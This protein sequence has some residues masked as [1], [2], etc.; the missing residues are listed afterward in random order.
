MRTTEIFVEQVIVGLLVL[1]TGALPFMNWER[2]KLPMNDL[3]AG[4]GIL[5]I[6]YLLGIVFD[7]FAD[8]LL[9]RAETYHRLRFAKGIKEKHP[10]S[11]E[12]KRDPYPED[13]MRAS[14]LRGGGKAAEYMEYLRARIRLSRAL[15]V[16]APALSISGLL[17]LG[18]KTLTLK[19]L[20]ISLGIL[21]LIY[22]LIF[23]LVLVLSRSEGEWTLPKTYD[24]GFE[25]NMDR[26]LGWA[27]P[28][29]VGTLLL[30]AC[31][32]ALYVWL[33]VRLP[34]RTIPLTSVLIFGLGLGALSAWSW[35]RI[36][37]TFME[38]LRAAG[39]DSMGAKGAC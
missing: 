28:T 12:S 19:S 33:T 29:A 37:R 14:I 3:V 7:R 38:F 18:R 35:W 1:A 32:I 39:R 26:F 36:T 13:Q 25:E 21:A 17:A 8:T 30:G 23:L 11:Q 2:P 16:C 24:E 6:A 4:A 27:E 22:L 15:A 34:A 20:S 9:S 31:A 5:L 10:E